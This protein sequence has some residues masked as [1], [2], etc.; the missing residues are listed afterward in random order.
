[1]SLNTNPI[2][3]FKIYG[4]QYKYISKLN[5]KNMWY[6]V[7][8]QWPLKADMRYLNKKSSYLSSNHK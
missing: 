3:I 4:F 2:Q 5:D 1:M 6:F 7:I 8:P